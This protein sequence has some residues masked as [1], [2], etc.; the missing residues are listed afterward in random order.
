MLEVRLLL[1]ATLL[2]LIHLDHAVTQG[3][4]PTALPAQPKENARVIVAPCSP[5]MAAQQRWSLPSASEANASSLTLRSAPRMSLHI[6]PIRQQ[7]HVVAV[8]RT[9]T[10]VS[11]VPQWQYVAN[12]S[13]LQLV[14]NSQEPHPQCLRYLQNGQFSNV[15]LGTCPVTSWDSSAGDL[16]PGAGLGSLLLNQSDSTV[17]F[18]Y[19]DAYNLNFLNFSTCLTASW[20]EPCEPAEFKKL[21]FCD[22][23]KSADERVN[24][25]LS[26]ASVEEQA[27]MLSN[28][29]ANR[30]WLA[31][32]SINPNNTQQEALHGAGASGGAPSNNHSL[33]GPGT[34]FGTSFPHA[35]AL[36]ATL[37]RTLWRLIGR[38]IAMESRAFSNQGV[39]GLYLRSPNLNIARDPRW[40]RLQET[41]GEDPTLVSE[42]GK[43]I[44]EGIAG[45]A[46]TMVAAPAPKH[47]SCYCGPEN[48]GGIMRWT[49]DAVV[50]EKY[51]T[52]YFFPGWR[53]AIGTGE[54]SHTTNP[55]YL[56]V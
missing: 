14:G 44:V 23:T 55:L 19:R 49:F 16:P 53:S 30:P 22:I 37:N 46:T 38:S 56:F 2:L 40:G 31:R 17:R 10:N 50:L 3:F 8:L 54:Q 15:A 9:V 47:F 43:A 24:D 34:G 33:D 35:L 52:S 26:R 12:T 28:D 51:L 11:A 18:I 42:Y 21:P 1:V 20:G 5:L 6:Q 27:A 4:V 29:G 32:L 45:N 25:L 39:G 13:A 7:A 48:W 36:A 41:A